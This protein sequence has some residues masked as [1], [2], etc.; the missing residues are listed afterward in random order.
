MYKKLSRRDFLRASA[1]AS[2]AALAAAHGFALAQDPTATP[3]PLPEGA[4]G[5]LTVIQ[6]TEYF[7]VVQEQISQYIRDFAAAKGMSFRQPPRTMP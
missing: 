3:A 4:A 7:P 6:K 2:A 1:G 5:T